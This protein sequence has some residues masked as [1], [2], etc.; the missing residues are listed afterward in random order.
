MSKILGIFGGSH[1]ASASYV[2]DGEIMCC[3]EEERMVRKKSGDD[4]GRA[5]EKAVQAIFQRYNMSI[6]D[7]DDIAVCAPYCNGFVRDIE[8]PREKTIVINHHSSHC[9]GAY[10][11]S[12]FLDKTLVFSYDGGGDQNYGKIYLAED[13]KMALVKRIPLWTGSSAGQ[14]YAHTTVGLGWK[15]LKDEGKV[16][17]LAAHGKF[18]EVI[19]NQLNKIFYYNGDLSFSPVDSPGK[20]SYILDNLKQSKHLDYVDNPN[21]SSPKPIMEYKAEIAYNVQLL[22]EN[23]MKNLFND[24]HSKYPQYKK[25]VLS[26]GIF[27]NVK[28][29]QRINELPWVDDIFISPPMGDEGLSLGAA[30]TL[31]F[32]KGERK[33]ERLNDVFLGLEYSNEE[34]ESSIKFDY[35]KEPYQPE[36]LAKELDSGKIA[37]WFQGRFEHGPRALGARSILVR[38]TD[39]NTHQILNERLGRHEIMPFAPFVLAEKADEIFRIDK[40]RMASEFMTMCFDARDGWAEKIPAVVH[41]DGTARPQ[42]VYKERNPKFHAVLESYNELTGLPILLNTSFNGHGEPIVN[43]PSEALVHLE[44]GM[45]DLLVAEDYIYYKNNGI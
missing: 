21:Y 16:T 17:G 33:T 4:F 34:I 25:L 14:I 6:N 20:A 13:N 45:V 31:A 1:N 35:R 44:N 41:I 40:S 10:L 8:A 26:G 24:L 7:F 29:N 23:E 43:S 3:I 37:G 39:P 22:I 18:N 2:K 28:L 36:V 30:L 15:M 5:P 27:A 19:Y 32:H 11:T 38:A 12:G 42:L 9:Y